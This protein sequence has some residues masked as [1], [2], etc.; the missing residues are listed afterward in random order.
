MRLGRAFCRGIEIELLFN[1]DK[2]VGSS[3]YLFASVL[4]R[5]LAQYVSINSFTRLVIKSIQ[6]PKV[7]KAWPPRNGN[8]ILL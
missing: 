7:I 1:E 4:E 2:Y 6:R 5:F 3:I 8:R